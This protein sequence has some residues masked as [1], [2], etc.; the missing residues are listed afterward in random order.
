MS[1]SLVFLVMTV[2]L[3]EALSSFGLTVEMFEWCAET[4]TS[5]GC[6]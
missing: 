4:V 1:G 5:R 6:V 3:E 2:V